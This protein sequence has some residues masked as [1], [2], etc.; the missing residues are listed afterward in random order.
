MEYEFDD[1][2]RMMDWRDWID[3][4][5]NPVGI[6]NNLPWCPLVDRSLRHTRHHSD[7]D[8]PLGYRPHGPPSGRH[9]T[10]LRTSPRVH[11]HN[12]SPPSSH[13]GFDNYSH[14]D[15]PRDTHSYR[16]SAL[17]VVGCLLFVVVLLWKS[18]RNAT[19]RRRNRQGQRKKERKKE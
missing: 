3:V 13:Y 19:F 16:D 6:C 1:T 10:L 15:T 8:R 5:K 12:R 7:I 18:Q 2:G 11:I 9:T 17:P 4:P 14:F